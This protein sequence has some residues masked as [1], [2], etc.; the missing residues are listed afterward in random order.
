MWI[1]IK[2]KWLLPHCILN[3]LQDK[4]FSSNSNIY[5]YKE[6][7]CLQI[8][9]KIKGRNFKQTASNTEDIYRII[10]YMNQL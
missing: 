8:D 7:I 6:F 4:T 9:G 10:F 1:I 3:K 5:I 2:K